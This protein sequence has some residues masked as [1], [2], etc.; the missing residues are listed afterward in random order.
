M[1]A[2]NATAAS[3]P[4]LDSVE[5][6]KLWLSEQFAAERPP[7][8]ILAIVCET[9][10]RYLGVSRVGYGEVEGDEFVVLHDRT[11]G[12]ATMVGRR[13]LHRDS[14]LVREYVRGRTIAATDVDG[15]DLTEAERASLRATHCRATLSVPLIHDGRFVALFSANHHEPRVW[16]EDEIALV[17]QTGA[18]TWAALEQARTLARLRESEEQFRLLADNMPGICWLAD[19]DGFGYWM[20]RAGRAYYGDA[21]RDPSRTIH[22]EDR[23]EAMRLYSRS[24]REGL[25]LETTV[26]MHGLDGIYRPL[27][28][29]T[30]PIRDANGAIT[31]WCGI[32]FDLSGQAARTEHEIFL[33]GLSDAIRDETEPAIILATVADML[34]AHLGATRVLYSEAEPSSEGPM[35]SIRRGLADLLP[36]ADN[37]RRFPAAFD[38]LFA[39]FARGETIITEDFSTLGGPITVG[40]RDYMAAIGVRSGISVPL[41]K[42]GR[43]DGILIVQHHLP[44]HWSPAE[45][46]LV[47]AVAE[48]TWATLTRAR[49]EEALKAREREQAF[50]IRWNDRVRAALDPAAITQITLTMLGGHLGATSTTCSTIE[51]D[52]VGPAGDGRYTVIAEWAPGRPSVLGYSWPAANL[53]PMVR[54]AYLAGEMMVSEDLSKDHRFSAEARRRF[55]ETGI[56]ARIGVPLARGGVVQAILA[57]DQNSPR[58]WHPAEAALVGEVADRMWGM[59][60]RARAE[61]SLKARERDQAFLVD[62]TDALRGLS[63]PDDIM[64]DTMERL[65]RHLGTTRVTYSEF[66]H[67][68]RVFTTR[69]DWCDGC[70]SLIGTRV[71][72]EAIGTRAQ[73]EWIAGEI[74]RYDDVASDPRTDPKDLPIYAERDIAA[75]VSIPL[76]RDGGVAAILSVQSRAPRAWKAREIALIRDM[77]ERTWNALER[78]R[79]Q[80]ELARRERDQAFVIAWSDR[81]RAETDPDAILATTLAALAG[82]LGTARANFAEPEANG[83]FTVLHEWRDTVGATRASPRPAVSD[84]VESS[85]LAGET[86]MSRDVDSDPRFDEAARARYHAVDAATFAAVPM[87]RS[88]TTCALLSVQDRSARDWSERELQLLREVADR[89]WTML[90]RARAEAS[91]LERERNQAFL[92]EWSDQLR[93]L[94]TADQVMAATLERLTR[95]LGITRTTYSINTGPDGEFVV[96]ANWCDGVSSV[97]G[98]RFSVAQVSQTIADQWRAGH[99]IRYDDIVGDPR[100]LPGR[101]AYYAEIEVRAFVTVPLIVEGEMRASLSAQ[102]RH[103]RGWRQSEIQLIRD[104]SERLWIALDRARA[105]AELRQRERDQAFLIGWSDLVRDESRAHAILDI[106]LE[107]VGRYLGVS[108]ANY[109]ESDEEGHALHVVREWTR[110]GTPA[111]L[112]QRFPFAQLGDRL[113]D[114]HFTGTPV[115]ID[116]IATDDRF[117]ERNRPLFESIGIGALSSVTLTRA[118][119]IVAILSM[120]Q[121][122][123]RAWRPSEVRLLREIADRTWATLE[124]AHAEEALERS[125]EALYQTEKLSALGSLLAGVSH[126]LNNP[127]SIVV[128]QAVMMERQAKGGDLAD[129]AF[130]IRKAADRCARI[131]QTFLAMA[132][133]KQPERQPV[134]LNQVAI[135]ALDLAEFGLRTEGIRIERA[136]DPALPQIAADADQLHQIIINLLINAQHALVGHGGIGERVVRITTARGPE[137]MTVVLDVADNG[138]GVPADARRRIFEPF[139]TTKT[140]GEGTGVG[141]SFSQGLAEAH[142]GRLTLLPTRTGATFRL[143]LPVDPQ[144]MLGRAEPSAA[145]PPPPPQRRA[146]V[147]DDEAEIAESLADF[148]SLE[149]FTCD[150]AVGGLAAKSRLAGGDYD[151]IVSDLRMPDMDGPALYDFVRAE[152]PDLASRVAF[153][154]GD[155]L[156]AAAARFIA[157]MQRPVLE[158]PFVPEAVRRFLDQMEQR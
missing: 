9:I 74:V 32:Q 127:L 104:V 20:N 111:L 108:R 137:P 155:T 99:V 67:D 21:V 124:R 70:P 105:L 81:L 93:Q 73:R 100:V 136:F 120:Q 147:I 15:L 64:L 135:A 10:A 29:R 42:A 28:T 54:S 134:D 79:T 65:G 83:G 97:V 22:P 5:A 46:A 102:S 62:W 94:S 55:A 30:V 6:V 44:R 47:E 71:S 11:D 26:R 115:V 146:L 91:L 109:S 95:H 39:A 153:A 58:R 45:I 141:L 69:W 57:I 18:R 3:P 122:E 110:D 112:G 101:E 152:R 92:V 68:D 117:D 118:G 138:P 61:Q 38:A 78:A 106:T 37:T 150:I 148:L 77:G 103:P 49:A 89:L 126:E 119:R 19:P 87:V 157:E 144:Q 76:I 72:L 123:P 84:A 50:L 25:P 154:T 75:F 14:G 80:A 96:V 88:G 40:T 24:T 59:L 145:E 131:V 125:R 34:K 52:P 133:A 129:R 98:R 86:V 33:R 13:P 114:S 107:W 51:L 31:R 151:L 17:A 116:D 36:Q 149:G 35:I 130:K 90:E 132:R 27:L 143:T 2:Q 43:L 66:D 7:A 113:L 121:A 12:L 8:A 63:E 128:A 156:G 60:E 56:V 139:F 82:H 85:Y 23:R 142:G 41:V 158:K 53:S 4:A 140:Q 48:R 16:A 1:R